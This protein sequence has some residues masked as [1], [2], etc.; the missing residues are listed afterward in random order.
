MVA[1]KDGTKVTFNEDVIRNIVVS[2]AKGLAKVNVSGLLSEIFRGV[3][4]DMPVEEI[5]VLM[6]NTAKTHIEDH[7]D[8]S[9][10]ASRLL[11]H[12]MYDDILNEY[13]GSEEVSKK[14]K[15]LSLENG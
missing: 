14:Y 11:L 2:A 1:K 5:E 4:N 7:Y 10:L 15:Q 6:I 13:Y 3:Y 12:K 9:S 8:Y